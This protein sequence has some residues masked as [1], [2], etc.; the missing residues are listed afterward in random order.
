[1]KF[2]VEQCLF[3]ILIKRVQLNFTTEIFSF[4]PVTKL[5]ITK[6]TNDTVCKHYVWEA[7]FF[8]STTFKLQENNHV[9]FYIISS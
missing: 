8:S 5:R 6:N 9:Q 7:W 1:M 2:A 3:F 4:T